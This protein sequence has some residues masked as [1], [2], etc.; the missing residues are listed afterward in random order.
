MLCLQRHRNGLTNELLIIVY[1]NLNHFR[2]ISD[3]MN[4]FYTHKYWVIREGTG[5]YAKI[6]C[7]KTECRSIS[8]TAHPVNISTD[9]LKSINICCFEHFLLCFLDILHVNMVW[10]ILCVLYSLTIV[11]LL[12]YPSKKVKIKKYYNHSSLRPNALNEGYSFGTS[13]H[14]K[15][16]Q[17]NKCTYFTCLISPWR[18]A[19][20]LRVTFYF[21]MIRLPWSATII[22]F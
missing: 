15:K 20:S 19:D 10:R 12:A 8:V 18:Q 22:Q 11:I 4:N 7:Y 3:N 13:N 21:F 2:V 6:E 17:K 1:I 14:V 9:K 16:K 5:I